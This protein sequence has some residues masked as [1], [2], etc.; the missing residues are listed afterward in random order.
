MDYMGTQG[1]DLA[2]GFPQLQDN[3]TV[4]VGYDANCLK[5]KLFLAVKF[6]LIYISRYPYFADTSRYVTSTACKPGCH[7]CN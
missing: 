3:G 7:I 6:L 2:R 1:Q 4:M 5:P